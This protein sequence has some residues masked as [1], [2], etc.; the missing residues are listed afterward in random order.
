MATQP[1]GFNSAES[2]RPARVCGNGR[3]HSVENRKIFITRKVGHRPI[4]PFRWI[5]EVLNDG[6]E[7]TIITPG[8]KPWDYYGITT[9]DAKPHLFTDWNAVEWNRVDDLTSTANSRAA[10]KA[11]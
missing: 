2:G 8:R 1:T 7:V 3:H 11:D 9:V 5:Q 4:I 6:A 10:Q